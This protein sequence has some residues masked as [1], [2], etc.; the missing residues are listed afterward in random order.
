MTGCDDKL[1][2]SRF[3]LGTQEISRSRRHNVGSDHAELKWLYKEA[4]VNVTV[5]QWM[6]GRMV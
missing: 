6:M 5:S 1:V 2:V 4:V 3:W